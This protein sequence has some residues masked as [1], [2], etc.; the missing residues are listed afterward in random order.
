VSVFPGEEKRLARNQPS[1]RALGV[2]WMEDESRSRSSFHQL[3][4]M[5]YQFIKPE[6]ASDSVRYTAIIS[7]IASIACRLVSVVLKR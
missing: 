2:R 5:V 4:A 7:A 3:H 1:A 6:I